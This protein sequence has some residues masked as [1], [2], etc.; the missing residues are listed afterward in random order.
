[1]TVFPLFTI[2]DRTWMARFKSVVI[3]PGMMAMSSPQL[4][5]EVGVLNF[6][7]YLTTRRATRKQILV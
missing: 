6:V 2:I 5:A 4:P 1:M 7:A 3:Y